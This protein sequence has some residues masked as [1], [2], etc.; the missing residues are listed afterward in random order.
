VTTG[1]TASASLARVVK[2]AIWSGSQQLGIGSFPDA[3]II[4]AQRSGTTS[5]EAALRSH[6]GIRGAR[7]EKEVHYFDL[8]WDR[9]VTWYRR[10]FPSEATRRRFERAHG[11]PLVAFEATPYY[12]VHPDVPRRAALTI[13]GARLLAILRNP[14]DRALSHYR[15]QRSFGAEDAATFEEALDLEEARLAGEAERLLADERSV[16]SEYQHHSYLTRGRYHEQL[17]RWL[18]RFPRDRLLVVAS[19]HLFADPATQLRR[20]VEFLGV[21]WGRGI[22]LPHAHASAGRL[23]MRHETRAR[24]DR[25]FADDMMRLQRLLGQDL[26]W[27]L[28]S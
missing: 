11:R 25:Y 10:Y 14:V 8:A 21:P 20:V 19:E 22:E 28:G 24:L 2:T 4:G 5:L 12:L 6:P 16:S 17:V 27:G 26:G 7:L 3:V 1:R 18:E 15:H 9:D 23:E 13:P